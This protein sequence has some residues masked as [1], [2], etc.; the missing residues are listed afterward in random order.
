M[1][2]ISIVAT[3]TNLLEGIIILILGT[4]QLL[5]QPLNKPKIIKLVL[6][7]LSPITANVVTIKEPDSKRSQWKILLNKTHPNDL[8]TN[9]D[10]PHKV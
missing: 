1:K 4:T 5:S 9:V 8:T 7:V 10:L 2:Y 6:L 3:L